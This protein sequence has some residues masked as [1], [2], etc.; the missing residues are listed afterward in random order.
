MTFRVSFSHVKGTTCGVVINDML[1]TG[2]SEIDN[3]N[4]DLWFSNFRMTEII[5]LGAY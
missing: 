4:L 5:T 3:Y 2:V 1:D